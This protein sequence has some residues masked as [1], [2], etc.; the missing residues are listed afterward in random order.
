MAYF[1]LQNLVSNISKNGMSKQNKFEAE[2]LFPSI[3]EQSYRGSS[4]STSVR[5]KSIT[6]P[7]RNI[8]TTTND[9][10]YGPTHEL[11]GGLSYADSV[12]ITFY[13]SEDLNEKKRFDAWQ[14][15]IYNPRTYNLNFYEDYIS[16]INIYQL[17]DDLERKYGVSLLECFPKTINQLDYSNESAS[18]VH[19]LT[20]AFAFKEWVELTPR[21]TEAKRRAPAVP[22]TAPVVTYPQNPVD[23][24]LNALNNQKR[25]VA[26]VIGQL[27]SF[28]DDP[29]A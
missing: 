11:A 3:V 9:T 14:E 27:N 26:E 10:I 18:A 2:I 4:V 12:D 28:A 8:T 21:G 13:L 19:D 22:E 6:M 16:T 5:I 25:N 17:G 1:N 24:D 23:R 15:W 29:S 7:G 20:V